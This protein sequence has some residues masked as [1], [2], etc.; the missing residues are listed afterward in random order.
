MDEE[1]DYRGRW[2]GDA[3]LLLFQMIVVVLLWPAGSTVICCLSRTVFA[4]LPLAT[5]DSFC[6]LCVHRLQ[7]AGCF[8]SCFRVFVPLSHSTP[9]GRYSTRVSAR[10]R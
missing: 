10:G 3:F 1:F 5:F 7:L 2:K 6:V 4:T 9:T 8:V